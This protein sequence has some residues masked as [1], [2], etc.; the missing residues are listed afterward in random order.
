M[1]RFT[2]HLIFISPDKL[3]KRTVIELDDRNKIS[4]IYNLDEYASELSQ[5][6]FYDGIISTGFVSVKQVLSSETMIEIKNNYHYLDLSEESPNLDIIQSEKK[7]L[8][9]FGDN[10]YDLINSKINRLADTLKQFSISEIINSCTYLPALLTNKNS[11]MALE[12]K[13]HLL[14]WNHVNLQ[15]MKITDKTVIKLLA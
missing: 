12:N 11:I 6:Q 5:T 13:T 1:K 9:D 10:G 4:N 14:Q 2:S 15:D 8:L 7:L 3:L